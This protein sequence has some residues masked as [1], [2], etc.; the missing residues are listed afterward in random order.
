APPST[1]EALSI[2]ELK[3]QGNLAFKRAA[4][5]KRTTASTQYLSEA[6]SY[7]IQAIQRVGNAK[8]NASNLALG[9]IRS[10]RCEV[11]AVA[12]P[13]QPFVMQEVTSNQPVMQVLHPYVTMLVPV[14]VNASG[15]V[16]P[17]QAQAVPVAAPSQD[18]T[19][20]WA[21]APNSP[22]MG[23]MEN[24]NFGYDPYTDMAGGYEFGSLM[25][26]EEARGHARRRRRM[27]TAQPKAPGMI[28]SSARGCGEESSLLSKERC[29]DLRQQLQAGHE[30]LAL[31]MSEIS[32]KVWPLS[33]DANGCRVVQLAMEK[34]SN[35]VAKDLAAELHGHVREA[36]VSPHANYVVQK[37]ITQLSPA[38]S[39]FI[40]EEL[41]GNAAR[42]ARH[43]FGCRIICR[44]LEH[45][46][47]QEGTLRLIDEVLEDPAEALDLCRHNFGHHVNVVQSILEHGD[48]RYKELIAEVL[49]HDLLANASHRSASYVVESA[50]SHCSEK[51]QQALLQQ[52]SHPNMVAELAQARYGF[53]VAKTLLQRPEVD[54]EAQWHARAA[55]ALDIS[56]LKM[57]PRCWPATFRQWLPCS[58]AVNQRWSFAEHAE[59]GAALVEAAA[60]PRVKSYCDAFFAHKCALHSNLAAVYLQ[61][62]PPQ[63]THAKAAADIALAFNPEHVK[64]RFRRAQAFLEDNRE[65][66]PE[67]AIRKALADLLQ[68]Q[69]QEPANAQIANEV[70]RVTRRLEV[71]ESKREIPPPRQILEQLVPASLLD[72]GSDCVDDHGYAWGQSDSI[73]HVFMPAQ[74]RRL[75]KASITCEITSRKLH[76]QLQSAEGQ[77]MLHADGCLHKSVKP[78]ESSWQLE[79]GGLLL[80]VE[81]AKQD[82]SEESEH[83]TRLWHDSPATNALSAKE[84]RELQQMAS[85]ACRE[86]AREEKPAVNE[87]ALRRWKAAMPGV[88]VQWADTSLDSFRN[89]HAA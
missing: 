47:S 83:W 82:V 17:G 28:Q 30:G 3:E 45:C 21:Y 62:V 65:G 37:V 53:Y 19:G 66:L 58:Q 7:Y 79:E 88:E 74:G 27:R 4:L 26:D 8:A 85:A 50:L 69:Q 13:H 61:E 71:L 9:L 34:A 2:E 56:R 48:V 78:D 29:D 1:S 72:R 60:I 15:P 70:K 10:A 23:P 35:G 46:S 44:L 80:H 41:L 5:L 33:R 63:W 64:A 57:R 31:A 18:Y 54:A 24:G 6:K 59:L 52:L 38:T 42:F 14:I 51:D 20:S 76:I 86:D 11:I 49:R 16:M 67:D 40:G 36:A 68:A 12:E 81:L 55:K 32:D 22:E 43:R 87:E 89:L 77:S 75:S 73:L 25:E 39:A 84:Q